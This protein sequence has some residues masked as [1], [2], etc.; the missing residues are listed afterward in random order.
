M[1]R[2]YVA[3]V[4]FSPHVLLWTI[5]P[6]VKNTRSSRVNGMRWRPAASSK[7]SAVATVSLPLSSVSISRTRVPIWKRTPLPFSHASRGWT[8]ESYSLYWVCLIIV[9][10]SSGLPTYMAKRAR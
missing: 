8:I 4:S 5:E 9:S 7:T 10:S 1:S 6:L 2:S 3:T